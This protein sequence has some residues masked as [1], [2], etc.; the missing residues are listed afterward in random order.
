VG[1][2]AGKKAARTL[3]EYID[4][5]LRI[6]AEEK[7]NTWF[8][9][10]SSASYQ[11]TPSVLRDVQPLADARGNLI[12]GKR[13]PLASGYTVTG[14]NPERMLD[15]FKRKSIPFLGRVPRND[16][17]WMVLMQH[18]GVPTRLLD[19]TTNAL[20]AL[21]F[22]V[23]NLDASKHSSSE[24]SV[25]QFLDNN[26]HRSDGAAIYAINPV[27]INKESIGKKRP[28]DISE[29]YEK[30][31]HYV[32]PMEYSSKV[33]FLP[34]CV[35]APHISPRIRAQSGTFTLHG[36]NIWALD[37]YVALRPLITKIFIPYNSAVK[38]KDQLSVLGMTT[39][40][41]FPDLD[42]IAAE[43]GQREKFAFKN[44]NHHY[45]VI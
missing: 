30:W 43:V 5:A 4:I 42:G 2:N 41:I 37:Y 28:I 7:G 26:E 12:K 31:K 13:V 25:E 23:S 36:A 19:W 6:S 38:I 15:D 11:L 45:P 35:V 32:R 3:S 34:I 22:A 20:V 14:I 24:E 8:R 44:K 9:G 39:S 17:E 1:R 21:Y 29:E 33:T 10:H 27:K 40:F 18:H 16:F